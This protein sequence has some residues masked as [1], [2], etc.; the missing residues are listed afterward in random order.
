MLSQ[1]AEYS[2]RLLVFL[3]R[4]YPDAS[5]SS[6]LAG[7]TQVPEAFCEKL[8][9]RLAQTGF[10]LAKRGRRGGY[11]LARSPEKIRV[12]EVIE[13]VD[14]LREYAS[15]PLGL[16]EHAVE[17]CPL[18]ARLNQA[19]AAVK[20]ILGNAT[21]RDMANPRRRKACSFPATRYR[22]TD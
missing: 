5:S 16:E 18:H 14:R 9:Q 2:L 11:R 17:L 4:R 6:E 20:R 8:L 19:V 10:V 3:A 15:C 12:V 21:L 1:T 13:Q 7:S 22:P